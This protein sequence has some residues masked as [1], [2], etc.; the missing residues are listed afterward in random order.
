MRKR[1]KVILSAVIFI[2]SLGLLTGCGKPTPVSLSKDVVV[3]LSKVKSVDGNI[4]LDMTGKIKDP[5]QSGLSL[6]LSVKLD[7]DY[8][9]T[10][11]P[12][13]AAHMTM[14]M[15]MSLLGMNYDTELENYTLKGADGYE[16][17]SRLEDTWYRQ[18]AEDSESE[19]ASLLPTDIFEALKDQKITA[20]I[21]DKLQK[22]NKKE[23]YLMH[24]TLSGDYLESFFSILGSMSDQLFE[25]DADFEDAIVKADIYIYKDANVPA[26]IVLDLGDLTN[27]LLSGLDT[28]SSAEISR[29]ALTMTFNSYNTVDE[30]Q[31]P[32]E[33]LDNAEEGNA[34]GGSL[35]GDADDE[36]GE[37][38]D[39]GD[40]DIED[41]DDSEE[42]PLNKAGN[43][44]LTNYAGDLQVEIGIPKDY[45]YSYSSPNYL[46][47][48]AASDDYSSSLDYE[49][50]E[51]ASMEEM[52]DSCSES[53]PSEEDEDYTDFQSSPERVMTVND[54]EV[55]YISARY[56]YDGSYSCMDCYAWTSAPDGTPFLVSI[57]DF[58]SEGIDARSAESLIETAFSKVALTAEEKA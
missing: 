47:L 14:K 13:N 12:D 48:S 4:N 46:G 23:A 58:A 30:I 6:D 5:S 53:F 33:V 18:S 16:T 37:D 25:D 40:P 44:V 28:G 17:Y 52:A 55:H 24:V 31:V 11:K 41:Y 26:K 8:Q 34:A 29:Y 43:Y 45:K 54:M 1:A 51:F 10:L 15:N 57:T 27:S 42:A 49:F 2:L 7:M 22:I 3:A 20:E 38:F 19:S 56:L 39:F 21:E 50:E 32:Q 36:F 35:F 9:T